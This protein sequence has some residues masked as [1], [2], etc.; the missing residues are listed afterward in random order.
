M[1]LKNTVIQYPLYSLQ[2]AF[3]RE[4]LEAFDAR[5]RKEVAHPTYIC[6]LK[7]EVCQSRLLMKRG[8]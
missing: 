6:E 4:E 5:V 2:D 3:S 7:I 8:F 1:V